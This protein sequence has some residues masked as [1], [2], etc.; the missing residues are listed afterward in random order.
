MSE[1]E[2]VGHRVEELGCGL[3]LSKSEATV[4]AIR[5]SVRQLM[6]DERFRRSAGDPAD[7]FI[8]AGV[9]VGRLTRS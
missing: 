6:A 3:Y 9:S 7:S 2:I 4:D 1:Q 8:D 5:A